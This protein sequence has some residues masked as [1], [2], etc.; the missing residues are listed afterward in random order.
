MEVVAA[1]IGA[2]VL[3]LVILP[4]FGAGIGL[5]LRVLTPYLF[6][7]GLIYLLMKSMFTHTGAWWEL[8]VPLVAWGGLVL[9]TRLIDTRRHAWHEGHWRAVM[10]A[11]TFG[12]WH[13]VR[14]E[15]PIV[16]EP[17]FGLPGTTD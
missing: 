14:L 1:V 7:G 3:F 4:L 8:T 6:G 13:K 12:F 17:A 5:V 15:V 9:G 11:V 2:F 10:I 16:E